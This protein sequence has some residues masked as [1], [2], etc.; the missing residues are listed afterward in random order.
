MSQSYSRTALRFDYG[1]RVQRCSFSNWLQRLGKQFTDDGTVNIGQPAFDSIVIVRQP[2]VVE[3]HQVQHC[4][5]KVW[6]GY[7]VDYRLPAYLIGC[8]KGHPCAQPRTSQPGREASGI[9]IAT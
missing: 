6:P 8:S 1:R 4:S 9:V 3:S 7:G 2:L 5:V